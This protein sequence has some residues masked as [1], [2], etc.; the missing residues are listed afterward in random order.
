M[1]S[2]KYERSGPVGHIVLC[3]PPQNLLNVE[4]YRQLRLRGH[5]RSP[6]SS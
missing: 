5:W 3:N 4:F 6:W 1:Q 2:V